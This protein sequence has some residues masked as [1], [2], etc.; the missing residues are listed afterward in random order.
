MSTSG[1]SSLGSA[2][3]VNGLVS[4]LN[5]SAIINAL[6]ASYEAPVTNLQNQQQALQGQIADFQA[7]NTD[8]LGL[9]TAAGALTQANQW[10]QTTASSSNSAVATA[11]TTSSTPSGS[12]T[13]TVN[14]LAAADSMVSSGTVA[15]T[16][17]SVTTATSF[18]LSQASTLGFSSLSGSSLALGS[19]ALTVTQA[20]AAASTTGTSALASSTSI[21][22]SNDTVNVTVDGVAKTLTIAT[23][24]YTASQLA[25]AVQTAASGAG[26]SASLTSAGDLQLATTDQG[27]GASLQVTG[28]T[29]LSAL[30]L[31]TMAS[32]TTGTD[33]VISVDGTSTTLTHLVA[34]GSVSLADGTGGSITAVLG[35][36]AHLAVGTSTA[37]NVSTGNGSLANVVAGINAANA[38]VTAAA[39]QTS[40]GG[41]VLQLSANS[42]GTNS[43]LT[44]NTAAFSPALGTLQTATAAANASLSVGGT[45]G[46]TV[47]SQTDSVSGLLPG[48]TVN[49]LATSATPVTITTAP[50]ASALSGKVQALVTAANTVLADIQKYGGYNQATKTAAP[51]FGN[52]VLSRLT[53]QV[54]SIFGSAVG[55][56]TL[57]STAV[58]G[59]S[60]NSN[61]TLSFDA[62]KFSAAYK[63]NPT[64]M[65]N[66]FDRGGTF[67]PASGF[68]GSVGLVYAGDATRAGKYQVVV[69][70]S[71]TQATDTGSVTF[72]SGSSTIAAAETLKVTMGGVSVSYGAQ[73]GESLS[74]IAQG[75]EQSFASSGLAMSAQVVA[76]G[77]G[78][79]LQLTSTGYGSGQSFSVATSGTTGQLG[80]A[81][82]GVSGTDVAGTINGVTATGNGQVL[83]APVGDPNLAGLALQVTASG[84]TSATTIGT[85]TYAPGLAAQI[86]SLAT[87]ET[88]PLS[89]QLT[90]TV[91]S[92]QQQSS[93]LDP[94]IAFYQSMVAQER[95]SLEATFSQLEA[96]LGLLKNQGSAL[97]SAINQL[98]QHL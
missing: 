63:A 31:A 97:S 58:A 52:P 34:G 75:L 6:L 1:V 16:T 44:V 55:S 8:M 23:G 49:L 20:S 82:A 85:Y 24:T 68:T 94:Q 27:S 93:G 41:Y 80:V 29:A 22:T 66:M 56:S 69:S 98:P 10:Q 14:Q 53:A 64:Q 42:T 13:F 65:A 73:A 77:T 81:T 51:L 79:A 70:H 54:L 62:T 48:L 95:K 18:L 43:T 37:T 38:G 92:L 86:S 40:S 60:V 32:V 46:Y 74:A 59:V 17:A 90:T 7:I 28:G 33:G 61:G 3:M 88:G 19:H 67:A 76:S 83:S 47:S 57:G 91:T 9:Q 36:S 39:I 50:D 87:A 12:V 96:Q 84:I 5:T 2:L 11:T 89:G 26:L 21:T 4:G 25:A 30:G 78:Y 72:S 45:G 35:S 71:A 15:A